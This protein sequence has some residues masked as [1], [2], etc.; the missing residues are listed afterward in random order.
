MNAPTAWQ[1]VCGLDDIVPD[2]GVAALLDGRQIA[3][4]RVRA[5]D[6]VYALANWDPFSRANVLARGLLGDLQ[7]ERVVAS[8]IYKQHFSLATGRCLEDATQNIEAYA[9]RVADGHIWVDLQPLR[10]YLPAARPRAEKLRLV[11]VGNGMAGMRV[12]EELLE[13]A[14]DLYRIEVFGAET[15]GNY[16]RILLSPLL[17][18]EKRTADIMLHP[19]AWY[20]ERGIVFHAGDAA[21]AI[22]RRRRTVHSQ[23]GKEI[24]YDRLLLATGSNPVVLPLPGREL[25]GVTTF[26]DLD[27]VGAMIAAA[28]SHRRAV[29]IGG[30]LLGLEAAHG[31]AK[32]G[33]QVSI[34]HLMDRLM[35]RQLD[36]PAAAMLRQKLESR[37]M[38]VHLNAQTEAIVG[39][40]RVSG[41]LLKDGTLIDADL[42]VMAVG[43]RPNVALAQ[44]SGLR[45][46][47]GV[48][49]NDTMQTFDPR[50]YAVGECVQHRGRTY[51]L[52]EPLWGQAHVCAVQ[53]GERGHARYRGS[54][55]A[56]QLKVAGIDV[57]SA[58][59]FDD[60]EG[61]D[62]L[63]LH[64]VHRGIYKRLVIRDKRVQGAVLYGDTRDG[65]WYFEL[66]NEKRDI[67]A[68]RNRL[69]FGREFAMRS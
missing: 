62:D 10:A 61:S 40:A 43:I 22:D 23:S 8:P 44:G 24:G 4:F 37:G 68:I 59:E 25:P 42:V 67:G 41:I 35:N 51:G 34:V 15:H 52:V 29:V 53:L 45:C 2:T 9:T 14:P 12:V 28:Q 27:D 17:A 26:R 49:V 32:R 1:P 38:V 57:F 66:I 31:L 65:A 7:G 20:E 36:A 69:L 55:L 50:I 11:V 21:V 47:R 18:G 13:A 64:D 58:G 54:L 3:V 5:D 16:N 60:A 30:G 33:M 63:V 56:T 39:D 46:E 19:P 6:R 48:L